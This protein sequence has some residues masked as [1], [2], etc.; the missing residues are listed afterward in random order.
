[1]EVSITSEG[2]LELTYKRRPKKGDIK[3]DSLVFTQALHPWQL[4]KGCDSRKDGVRSHC[5]QGSVTCS[6]GW[7][8]LTFIVTGVDRLVRKLDVVQGHLHVVF[9]LPV[10]MNRCGSGDH[11]GDD[12]RRASEEMHVEL[13]CDMIHSEFS[14]RCLPSL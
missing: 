13:V 11:N 6:G 9:V 2:G 8:Y 5:K 3:R 14:M 12:E 7:R 1:M 10:S 4:G